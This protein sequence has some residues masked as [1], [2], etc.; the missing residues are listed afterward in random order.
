MRLIEKQGQDVLN[1]YTISW[2]VAIYVTVHNPVYYLFAKLRASTISRRSRRPLWVRFMGLGQETIYNHF[3]G[4]PFTSLSYSAPPPISDY[5]RLARACVLSWFPPSY[6]VAPSMAMYAG[7]RMCMCSILIGH[8]RVKRVFS[9]T[10]SRY[11]VVHCGVFDFGRVFQQER[12]HLRLILPR[13]L[14]DMTR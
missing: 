7:V 12:A 8:M 4:A 14:V 3:W 2:T 13:I 11:H 9:L 6:H 5:V 1:T 10:L